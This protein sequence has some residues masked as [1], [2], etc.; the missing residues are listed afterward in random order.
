MG[1]MVSR[2]GLRAGSRVKRGQ[3]EPE[4]FNEKVRT[5][6]AANKGS[7]RAWRGSR[8]RSWWNRA[9]NGCGQGLGEEVEK[10]EARMAR[11]V[12]C[13]PRCA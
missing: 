6:A 10:D 12:C 8:Q 2:V 1:L 4:R 3:A 7:R 5:R 13:K 11:R 9:R